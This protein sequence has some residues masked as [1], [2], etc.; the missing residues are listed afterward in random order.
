MACVIA[1]IIYLTTIDHLG[2]E[3]TSWC[4]ILGAVPF[5][6]LGF[7]TFQSMNAED[8]FIS[9][10]LSFLLSSRNLIDKPTNLYYERSKPLIS[11]EIKEALRKDVKKSIKDTTIK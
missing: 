4:C 9:L 7:I 1:V 5:A 6:T 10:W 3:L 11:K 8:I 2:M